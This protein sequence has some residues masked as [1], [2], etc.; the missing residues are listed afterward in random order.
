MPIIAITP[1]IGAHLA[2]DHLAER[3]AVAPRREE[4]HQHVLHRA[5]EHHADEDP[6]RARQVAHLRREHR[7]DQRS[8]AGDGGEVMAEQDAA[9]PGGE[10]AA[11]A[12]PPP[13]GPL[14]LPSMR[15]ACTAI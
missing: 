2:A 7:A 1:A 9:P 15:S 12:V 3:A 11:P 8:G 13:G 4:Q 5:G 10:A 6:E 14:R